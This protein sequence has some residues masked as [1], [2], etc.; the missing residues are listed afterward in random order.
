[1]IRMCLAAV[2]ALALAA[3]SKAPEDVTARY[4]LGGGAGAITVQAAGNGDARVEAGQQLLVRK[5]G[6]EYVVLTDSKGR[7]ATKMSDFVDVMGEMMKEA[8]MKPMGMPPQSEY[9]LVKGGSE[10]IADVK[11]DVWKVSAKKGPAAQS[12]E[13]VISGDPAYAGVG[14]AL[15]MQTNLGAAQAKQIQG[16]QGNLEKR[17]EEMLGKGMVLRFADAL[18]LDKVEKGAIDP[19]NFDLPALVDKA[20][21]KGRMTAERDRAQAAA[22]AMPGG[23]PPVQAQPVPAPAPAPTPEPKTK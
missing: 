12:F 10:T 9:D 13:A 8:G 6:T 11:G 17:V 16:G 19:K 15:E 14:K 3:C 7:F 23:P 21:L 4:T 18:K 22:K 1:M 20:A 5:G 2:A